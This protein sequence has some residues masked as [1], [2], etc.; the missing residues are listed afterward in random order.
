MMCSL[1]KLDNVK[2]SELNEC[3]YDLG[4]YF[5]INGGERVIISQERTAGNQIHVFKQNKAS[6]NIHILLKLNL[7]I[8]LKQ[9][10][11]KVYKLNIYQRVL[12]IEKDVSK[13]LFL[14]FVKM[15]QCV[16]CLEH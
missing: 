14:I 12:K 5:I 2:K 8:L 9:E 16:Y 13:H 11:L 10:F 7:L 1:T 6:S 15:F 3:K 4:G